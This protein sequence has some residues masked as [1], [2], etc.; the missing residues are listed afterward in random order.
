MIIFLPRYGKY[1]ASSRYRHY[2]LASYLKENGYRVRIFPFYIWKNN[3]F[4]LYPFYFSLRLIVILVYNNSLFYIEGDT[5]PHVG[6]RFAPKNYILD[7]DDPVWNWDKLFKSF[8]RGKWSN[9]V[10]KS[11]CLVSGSKST[12]KFWEG[13]Q[14][15]HHYAITTFPRSFYRLEENVRGDNKSVLWIGSPSTSIHVDNIFRREPELLDKFSWYLIGYSGSLL[16]N[17]KSVTVIPWSYNAELFYASKCDVAISP[18]SDDDILTQY[19]CG[20]KIVQYCALGLKIVLNDSGVNKEWLWLNNISVCR[21]QNKWS[22]ALYSAFKLNIKRVEIVENFSREISGE[23]V[24]E[25]IKRLIDNVW[26]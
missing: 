13:L 23:I 24:F 15:N 18:L 9:L 5:L 22:D 19:K 7:F 12:L 10:E 6:L 8:S 11:L 1:A 25:D 16:I 4:I 20:F 17:Q 3:K 26:N 21:Y 14:P 2:F